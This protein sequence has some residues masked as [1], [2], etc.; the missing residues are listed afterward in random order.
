MRFGGYSRI[1]GTVAFYQ[2]VRAL[3]RADSIVLDVGC[4]RGVL[5]D[6]PNPVRRNLQ[7]LRGHCAQVIG[8]DVDRSG[9]HNPY[10]DEFRLIQGDGWPAAGA[11]LVISDYVLEH[12]SNPAGY[13]REAWRALVPGGF[14]CIRT[15]NALGY[16]AL[17]ARVIPERYHDRFLA[18]MRDGRDTFPTLY[19]CN[20]V[21]RIQRAMRAAGFDCVVWGHTAEPRYLEF[22]PTLY[23]AS[24]WFQ[25]LAPHW[26]APTLFAFGQ[27]P[28]AGD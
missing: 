20:S 23:R 26:L 27:K 10:L 8:L 1:D 18:G 5:A 28:G 12:L 21:R 22:S 11:D 14:I 9:E 24:L 2:R 6:D 15:T 17:S 13:F 3:L 19:R 4:G 25:H 7:I 16:V